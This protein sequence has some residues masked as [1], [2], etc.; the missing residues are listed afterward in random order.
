MNLCVAGP[1]S[2]GAD[3]SRYF[4]SGILFGVGSPFRLGKFWKCDAASHVG[5]SFASRG[6][7]LAEGI[8]VHLSSEIS[9]T[10]ERRTCDAGSGTLINCILSVV[11][12]IWL[13][14]ILGCGSE[15]LK[16][17]WF[18]SRLALHFR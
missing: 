16:Q 9:E 15:E 13:K 3:A 1:I 8:W 11:S 7:S 4:S 12:D 2:L 18:F 10:T 6:H 5:L 17:A 14:P